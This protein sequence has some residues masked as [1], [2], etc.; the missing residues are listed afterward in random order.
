M[1]ENKQKNYYVYEGWLLITAK[2]ACAIFMKIN[3]NYYEIILFVIS[4]LSLTF[5]F[6][7]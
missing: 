5:S 6:T 4:I 3:I 2:R 1:I 7:I